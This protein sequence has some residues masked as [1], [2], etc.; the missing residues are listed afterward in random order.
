MKFPKILL[1]LHFILSFAMF[2]FIVLIVVEEDIA[3]RVFL[4]VPVVICWSAS[5]VLYSMDQAAK[6]DEMKK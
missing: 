1:P 4:L 3:V 2:F 5:K 6:I